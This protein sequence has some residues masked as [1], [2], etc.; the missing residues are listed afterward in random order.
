[1]SISHPDF[2]KEVNYMY[3]VPLKSLFTRNDQLAK[4]SLSQYQIPHS[5][6]VSQFCTSPLS[7]QFLRLAVA[8]RTKVL[9]IAY[10]H[11]ASM[12]LNGSPIMPVASRL[13]KDTFIKHRVGLCAGEIAFLWRAVIFF[14][15]ARQF[16][17]LYVVVTSKTCFFFIRVVFSF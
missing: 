15:K 14:V 7:D 12:M 11:P 3:A 8:I 9:M 10:K 2:S 1:M 6:N 16:Y 17:M 4:Q 13:P 5:K